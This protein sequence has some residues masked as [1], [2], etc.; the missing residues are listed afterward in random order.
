MLLVW[1]CSELNGQDLTS[2]PRFRNRLPR[3]PRFPQLACGEASPR[4]TTS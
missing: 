3:N 4:V 1:I 2:L